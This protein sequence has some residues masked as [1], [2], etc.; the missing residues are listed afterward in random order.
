[1][2]IK[3]GMA[4]FFFAMSRRLFDLKLRKRHLGMA[5]RSRHAPPF[6]SI[7]VANVAGV[8][9]GDRVLACKRWSFALWESV[10]CLL[11]DRCLS[12]ERPSLARSLTVSCGW[13]DAFL[14]ADCRRQMDEKRR[15]GSGGIAGIDYLCGVER[16][17]SALPAGLC[18]RQAPVFRGIWLYKNE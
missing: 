7:A 9:A 17:E 12:A 8:G 18:A 4:R 13:S 10:V 15:M 14:F 6:L 16:R 1:M 2:F 5:G 3:E 11:V